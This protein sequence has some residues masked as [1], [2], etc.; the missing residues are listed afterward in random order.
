[1]TPARR[2]RLAVVA[3]IGVW[4]GVGITLFVHPTA[5]GALAGLSAAV[6]G[7]AALSEVW[8]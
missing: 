5:G 6:A 4:V 7:V 3:G 8:P 1:M 2:F